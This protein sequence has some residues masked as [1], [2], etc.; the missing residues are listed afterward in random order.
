MSIIPYTIAILNW[1]CRKS[2][3]IQGIATLIESQRFW[4]WFWVAVTSLRSSRIIATALTRAKLLITLTLHCFI[5]CITRT[6]YVVLT[7]KCF[8]HHRL[9]LMRI[10]Q[11]PG[12]SISK[13]RQCEDLVILLMLAWKSRW[14]N[15]QVDGDLKRYDSFGTLMYCDLYANCKY[16][17]SKFVFC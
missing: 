13:G 9:F 14:I 7:W 4:K 2:S 11:L 6:H 10:H 5:A 1:V 12:D 3:I 16:W 17:Y 15:C 8:P